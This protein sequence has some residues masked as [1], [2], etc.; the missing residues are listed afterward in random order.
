MD[1][2]IINQPYAR[3]AHA[4]G[5]ERYDAIVIGSGIGGLEPCDRSGRAAWRRRRGAGVSPP[6]Q[7]SRPPPRPMIR[8]TAKG[9][10]GS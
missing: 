5:N 9:C 4:L 3:A 6:H 10:A 7:A 8:W 1:D 2:S